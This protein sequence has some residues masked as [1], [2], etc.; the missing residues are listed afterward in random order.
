MAKPEIQNTIFAS[1]QSITQRDN[2]N[3][4]KL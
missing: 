1:H 2:V 3:A 4:D